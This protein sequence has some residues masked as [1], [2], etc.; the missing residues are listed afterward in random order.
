MTG[1]D[2]VTRYVAFFETLSPASLGRLGEV[3]DDDARFVDPFNDVRGQA[4]IRGVFEHMFATCADP[5]FFVDERCQSAGACYL[6]WHFEYGP[7]ARRRRI[8]G[9]S[10]VQFGAHGRAVDHRDYWDAAGQL[11]EQ[12]PLVGWLLRRL[13]RRLGARPIHPTTQR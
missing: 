10:R 3:F 7:S 6:R 2:A 8:D 1:A 5:R 4:A 11:Y 12:I 9:V 13:R